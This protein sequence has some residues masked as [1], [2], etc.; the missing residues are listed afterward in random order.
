MKR[1]FLGV[2]LFVSLC[3]GC[4]DFIDV[5]PFPSSISYGDGLTD[6]VELFTDLNAKTSEKQPPCGYLRVDSANF[7]FQ[8]MAFTK[9]PDILKRAFE[10]YSNHT[11]FNYVDKDIIEPYKNNIYV[12]D[13]CQ[14]DNPQGSEI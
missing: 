13:K 6:N 9:M 4:S 3:L 10:R 12:E 1:A 11:F 5:W 2:C 8:F 7:V 14:L